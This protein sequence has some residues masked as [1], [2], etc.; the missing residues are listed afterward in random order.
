MN[1]TMTDELDIINE[2]RNS[3]VDLDWKSFVSKMLITS[4]YILMT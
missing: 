4:L 3:G 2:S 1:A